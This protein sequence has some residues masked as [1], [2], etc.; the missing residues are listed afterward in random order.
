MW[1]SG[2]RRLAIRHSGGRSGIGQASSGQWPYRVL[3]CGLVQGSSINESV[4][5]RRS[6]GWASLLCTGGEWLPKGAS[7]GRLA[8]DVGNGAEA[9]LLDRKSLADKTL[10]DSRRGTH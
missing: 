2:D 4:E 8:F 3:L 9:S 1:V 6:A 5:G 7:G 10:L